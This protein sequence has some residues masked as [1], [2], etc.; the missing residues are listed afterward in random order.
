MQKRKSL[1][2]V[3]IAVLLSV[4]ACGTQ[5]T[6]EPRPSN[7]SATPSVASTSGGGSKQSTS[8]TSSNQ[9]TQPSFSNTSNTSSKPSS[10]SSSSS[11]STHTHTPGAAVQE[12]VVA[13]TCQQAGSYDEVIY[14]TGCH[15]ELSRTHKTTPATGQHNYVKN[16]DTLEYV[17][18][19][20]GAKNGRAYEL[21]V[22]LDNLHVDDRLKFRANDFTYSFKNDD[23]SLVFLLVEYEIGGTAIPFETV[24]DD[25]WYS[26]PASLQG[27]AVVAKV[28]ICVKED[29]N[30]K[31]QG[32]GNSTILQNVDVYA[33]GSTT[34]ATKTGRFYSDDMTNYVVGPMDDWNV[35]EY[36]VNLGNLL[37]SIYAPWPSEQIAS[38]FTT[39]GLTPFDIPAYR[40][41]AITS[42]SVSSSATTIE[43]V[44]NGLKNS[45]DADYENNVR[46]FYYDKLVSKSNFVRESYNTFISP[47][48][49]F[50]FSPSGR[51]GS[52]EFFIHI[53]KASYTV[54]WKNY[55][56]T[57]LE[58]DSDVPAGTT[59]IYDGAAPTRATDETYAYYF[60]GW[61]KEISPVNGNITYTATYEQTRFYM[62]ESEDGW[63][64]TGLI[65]LD[66]NGELE[67]EET[68]LNKPVI[69]IAANAFNG[70]N[71]VMTLTLPDS[72]KSIGN[73]AFA[74]MRLMVSFTANNNEGNLINIGWDLFL[75]CSS[76]VNLAIPLYGHIGT[77]FG[78]TEFTG[79]SAVT[80]GGETY[81]IPNTLKNFKDTGG[82][83]SSKAFEGT[84]L[85]T[86]EITDQVLY[87][88]EEALAGANSLV[89]LTIPY[90]GNDKDATE[91]SFNTLF[92]VLFS[93]TTYGNTIT[94]GAHQQYDSSHYTYYYLPHSLKNVTVNGGTFLGYEF[95]DC[96]EL[97]KITLNDVIALA[98]RS[99]YHCSANV[100]M[101]EGLQTI[102]DH[103]FYYSDMAGDLVIPDSVTSIGEFAFIDAQK[104][105]SFVVGANVETLGKS[106]FSSCKA[107]K[108]IT[109]KGNKITE[110][111][112]MTFNHCDALEAIVVPEGVT[113]INGNA[114]DYCGS[115]ASVSL[116]STLVSL[117]AASIFSHNDVLTAINYNGTKAMWNAIEKSSNWYSSSQCP[118]LKTI[119]CTDG[120][121][122]L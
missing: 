36:R 5:T 94:Y 73:N 28:Y 39:L 8:N 66:Y 86:I 71:N 42:Y 2:A 20:C 82:I 17:C 120:D 52:G 57:V 10:S 16:N 106:A 81:Y 76:L 96:N 40:D 89:N 117:K 9:S 26:I 37:P 50:K 83:L 47:D 107:A 48:G 92:G 97:E 114:F 35:Y 112:S 100:I 53:D 23:N 45:T 113:K 68:L 98:N 56:G 7:S 25:Y 54:T 43:I 104:I 74:N 72:I 49:T 22:Q 102:G 51:T 55:D 29:A 70:A 63:T 1:F 93:K 67:V 65:E 34:P 77:L 27:K 101:N 44:F 31:Y 118:N 109:F 4:C 85:T 122:T 87:M 46:S 21:N 6:V 19:V 105:T 115:L 116:P 24:N 88:N 58:T 3:A 60:K 11:A 80:S 78:T 18:S 110:I 38:G 103:A 61:D 79:A 15:Q 30:I 12:N 111:Q 121:I 14:C 13:A 95:S 108:S 90:V 69:A 75:G 119:H 33:N 62:S 64:V 32:Q 99:F 59:P 41:A 84:A 91:P